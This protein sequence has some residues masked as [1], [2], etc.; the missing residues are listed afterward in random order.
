MHLQ[1]ASPR[2][3]AV[4][5]PDSELLLWFK[6]WQEMESCWPRDVTPHGGFAPSCGAWLNCC[7][8]PVG[9][10]PMGKRCYT[11]ET[12]KA[13]KIYSH[14]WHHSLILMFSKDTEQKGFRWVT[15][16]PL[17][18]KDLWGPH[19][20]ENKKRESSDN[21]VEHFQIERISRT[22]HLHRSTMTGHF[23]SG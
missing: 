19:E 4:G 17:R 5:G 3:P 12:V 16:S 2:A 22:V 20:T 1:Q 7:I 23:A 10:F 14:V 13:E 11:V 15:V 18:Q 8:Q 6:Q 9:V 21:I